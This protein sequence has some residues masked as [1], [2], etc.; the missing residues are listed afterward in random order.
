MQVV[1]PTKR[2]ASQWLLT[3]SLTR[4]DACFELPVCLALTSWLSQLWQACSF[5]Y[6]NLPTLVTPVQSRLLWQRILTD[7]YDQSNIWPTPHSV[8]LAEQAFRFMIEWQIPLSDLESAALGN[9]ACFLRWQSAYRQVLAQKG[10]LDPA[11]Q[12]AFMIEHAA[13]FLE[14]IPK[15]LL[16]YG[17]DDFSPALLRWLNYL[18]EHGITVA[19]ESPPMV[20]SNCYSHFA[21]NEV[22]ELTHA[23]AWAD[24]QRVQQE[25]PWPIG[26]V[27]PNLTERR[28]EIVE[29]CDAWFNVQHTLQFGEKPPRFFNVSGGLS[30]AKTPV[31]SAALQCLQ[32][33]I[34]K[35]S[36]VVWPFLLATPFIAGGQTFLNQRMRARQFLLHELDERVESGLHGWTV[37]QD[38]LDP[39]DSLH[40][41]FLH[42][43]H[44]SE[45]QHQE[46]PLSA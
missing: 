35:E 37:I 21:D 20:S 43:S 40:T 27:V 32:C 38:R 14:L 6:P 41:V 42:W 5:E 39:N 3:Q 15:E 34:S 7:D 2:L 33:L 18:S 11:Q 8:Y 29:A 24:A 13:G 19:H 46:K 45:A 30:L 17:F 10:W 25:S 16:C 28:E 4:T 1:T 22:Q 31:I 12:Y 9:S 36:N 44:W 23:L 26:I